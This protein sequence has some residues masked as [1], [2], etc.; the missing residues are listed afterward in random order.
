LYWQFTA[1][2]FSPHTG[3]TRKTRKEANSRA[4]KV[5]KSGV[6]QR[7]KKR[8]KKEREKVRLA[9]CRLRTRV[10]RRAVKVVSR[11]RTSPAALRH[12]RPTGE[13]NAAAPQTSVFAHRYRPVREGA[14]ATLAVGGHCPCLQRMILVEGVP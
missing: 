4:K 14:V 1:P 8:E 2:H 6:W 10:R 11:R 12:L 9:A 13:M 7:W 3:V 5:T